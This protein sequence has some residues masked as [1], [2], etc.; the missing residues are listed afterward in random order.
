MLQ[1][2]INFHEL[3]SF[4]E[5]IGKKNYS[6]ADLDI[7]PVNSDISETESVKLENEAERKQE[8]YEVR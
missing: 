2:V 1:Y 7:S 6:P 5:E 3:M 8:T 4:Q